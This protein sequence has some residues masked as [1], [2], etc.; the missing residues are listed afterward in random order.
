MKNIL[1]HIQDHIKEI[2]ET[3]VKVSF[4]LSSLTT[5][6]K[7][8]ICNYEQAEKYLSRE[9]FSGNSGSVIIIQPVSKRKINQ[10]LTLKDMN[11]LYQL[12][13]TSDQKSVLQ[14]G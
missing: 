4:C 12:I 3:P 7:E 14:R 10:K 1:Y 8:I 2:Y 13:E 11:N 6:I 9:M 5:D